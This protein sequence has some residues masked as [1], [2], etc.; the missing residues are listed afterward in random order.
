MVA[1]LVLAAATSGLIVCADPR[2]LDGDT[3]ICG[4]NLRIRLWGVDSP[5]RHTPA[6]PAATRALANLT[7][8]QT[9]VCKSKGR[10]HDRTVAQCWIGRMDVGGEMVR[11]G[12]AVDLPKYSR[13]YYARAGR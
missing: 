9:L 13:G 4:G 10:S 11:Q 5:E 7:L 8:G 6:G 12:Q 1:T 3:F 2:P